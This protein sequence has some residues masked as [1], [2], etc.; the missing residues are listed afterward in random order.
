MNN[1][2]IKLNSGFVGYEELS[3]SRGAL[4]T[5]AFGLDG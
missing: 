1:K 5:S 3:R 4:S 2:A